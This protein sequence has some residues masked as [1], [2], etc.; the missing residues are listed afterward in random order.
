[1]SSP[2]TT[3]K[4]SQKFQHSP[5]RPGSTNGLPTSACTQPPCTYLPGNGSR[6]SSWLQSKFP[7]PQWLMVFSSSPTTPLLATTTPSFPGAA[8]YTSNSAQRTSRSC[9][10]RTDRFQELP[11]V[12]QQTP[13]STI[14]D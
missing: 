9:P 7:K 6:V 11:H 1:M 2:S 14:P 5:L 8:P 10:A 12:S 13:L 3:K 4:R